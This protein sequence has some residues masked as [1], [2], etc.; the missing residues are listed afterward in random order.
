VTLYD[1]ATFVAVYVDEA[2]VFYI[3]FEALDLGGIYLDVST[4]DKEATWEFD[5]LVIHELHL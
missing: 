3:P 2:L 1:G 4:F 5:N